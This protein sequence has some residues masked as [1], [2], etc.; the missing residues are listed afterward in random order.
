MLLSACGNKG[1]LFLP[2]DSQVSRELDE[3]GNPQLPVPDGESEESTSGSK[4]K[5]KPQGS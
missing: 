1:E 4:S 5:R 3:L 2:E